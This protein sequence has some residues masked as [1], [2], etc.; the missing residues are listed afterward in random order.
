[1]SAYFGLQISAYFGLKMCAYF[2]KALSYQHSIS[3]KPK[4]AQSA[5]NCEDQWVFPDLRTK[6]VGKLVKRLTLF[7]ASLIVYNKERKNI[8]VVQF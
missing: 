3:K 8:K 4:M 1:M 5:T 6:I 2:G 7:A